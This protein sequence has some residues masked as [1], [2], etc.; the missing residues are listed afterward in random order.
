M[1][2]NLQWD[3]DDKTVVLQEYSGAIS[4]DDLYLLAE[5]SAQM[6]AT[7]QHTVHLIIDER[8]H[9]FILTATDMTYLEQLTPANQGAVVVIV[10]PSKLQY[11]ATVQKI[12]KRIGPHAFAEAYFVKSLPEARQLLHDSFGVNYSVEALTDLR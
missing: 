6:L 8:E 5:K 10:P 3:T 9:H 2:H 4:N 1:G 7:V 11:K 12:G